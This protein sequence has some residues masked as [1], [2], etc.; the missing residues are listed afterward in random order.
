MWKFQRG[1]ILAAGVS[2]F[3]F[4][5]FA[6]AA[7]AATPPFTQCPAIGADSS[8]AIL[9]T[10]NANGSIT[11]D[12][13]A[14]LGPYDSID[15]TL[16]GVQNNSTHAVPSLHLVGTAASGQP[17][18]GFDFD[19][20]CSGSF[21]GTPAGCP[22]GPTG[23]EGPN[24]S[25]SNISVDLLSGDV[26]FTGGL[27]PGAS[28]YFSLEGAISANGLSFNSPPDCSAATTN[29]TTLWPPNHRLVPVVIS[30]VTD[31]NADPL[32]IN[33]T[34]VTQDEP[35]NGL[36][37]GDTGPADA[38]ITPNSSTVQIRA[39]RSG[40]GDGRVYVISFTATDPSGASCSGSLAVTVQHDQKPGH[41]A[42]D[43]GQTFNSAP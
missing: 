43:S 21:I 11:V 23:Y 20:I 8:C 29:V 4:M 12:Q 28:A 17:P 40:T 24:T 10:I 31:P 34:G 22:F 33:V 7:Q 38:V 27:A 16:I 41:V 25:F 15:D 13:D 5:V 14:S 42:V 18:F 36:G 32:T 26:N 6:G 39:E 37:D 19:G 1:A 9:L 35:T 30:G 3:A 2:V